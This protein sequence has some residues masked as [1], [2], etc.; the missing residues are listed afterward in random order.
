MAS[1]NNLPPGV[2][3]VIFKYLSF[4]DVIENCA[5]VCVQWQSV[6]AKYFFQPYLEKLTNYDQEFCG[7]FKK[8]GWSDKCSNPE[9]ILSFYNIFEVSNYPGMCQLD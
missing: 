4:R 9:K 5:K 6:A 8:L 7:F 3:I 1:I 2:L